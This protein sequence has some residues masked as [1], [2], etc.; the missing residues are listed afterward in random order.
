MA[1]AATIIT[2]TTA[3]LPSGLSTIGKIW[4]KQPVTHIH[5]HRL[6]MTAI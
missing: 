5:N 2:L 3:L 6:M 4:G 1:D